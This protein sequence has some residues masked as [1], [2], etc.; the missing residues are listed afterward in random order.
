MIICYNV[1]KNRETRRI[2]E[3]KTT[4]TAEQIFEEAISRQ[5][6]ATTKLTMD[7]RFDDETDEQF[8]AKLQRRINYV[9]VGI[10]HARTIPGINGI[11]PGQDANWNGYRINRRRVDQ[12]DNVYV[13][14][15]K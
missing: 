7:C 11:C 5:E 13:S 9:C 1:S 15:A 4:K 6:E 12:L 14:R 3:M 10:G 2:R 8:E